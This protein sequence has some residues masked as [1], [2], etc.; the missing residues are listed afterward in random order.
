MNNTNALL[1]F[2]ARDLDFDNLNFAFYPRQYALNNM[3]VIRPWPE[4]G[5]INFSKWIG[6]RRSMARKAT[7]LRGPL[8]EVEA[9]V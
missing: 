8:C 7:A 6:F 2:V 3:V 9:R 4:G 1:K 5:V